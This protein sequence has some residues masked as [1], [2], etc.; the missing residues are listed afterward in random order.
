MSV[1]NG[2]G[3]LRRST[4][5]FENKVAIITGAAQGIGK[6]S[7][8]K[9]AEQGCKIVIADLSD[10]SKDVVNEIVELG[11]EAIDFKCNVTDRENVRQLLKETHNYFGQIDIL[12]NNAGITRDAQIMKM[13]DEEWDAV[14]DVNLK[15]M[16]ITI[17]ESLKYMVPRNYGRIVNISSAAGQMG[18][19][20][21]ANYSAAKGGVIS[22]TKTLSK[23]LS[24]QGITINAIAPGFVTT[25]MM[26][27]VPEEIR[28]KITKMIP[29]QRGATPEEIANGIAFLASDDSSYITGQCLNINGGLYV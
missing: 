5:R 27:E 14:L 1:F 11:S 8:L 22:L 10:N 16:F 20:G 29:M 24:S 9:L 25:E 2:L 26:L 7:A 6:A 4:M 15:S 12:V 28:K 18:N 3:M 17:Q 19:F 13:T 21:Q 23:E